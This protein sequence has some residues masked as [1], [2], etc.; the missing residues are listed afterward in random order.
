MERVSSYRSMLLVW[1]A[2]WGKVVTLDQLKRRAFSLASR[3]FCKENDNIEY[4][5]IHCPKVWSLWSFLLASLGV[6]W[7]DLIP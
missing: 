6:K 7:V 4:L 2:W 5:L 1:E 3:C